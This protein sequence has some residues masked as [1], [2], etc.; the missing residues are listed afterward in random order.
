MT[1]AE[2]FDGP[3]FIADRDARGGVHGL[4]WNG[5][6]PEWFWDLRALWAEIDPQID[7]L[8]THEA[9]ARE[10]PGITLAGFRAHVFRRFDEAEHDHADAKK[11]LAWIG[12]RAIYSQA[13]LNKVARRLNER[14]RKTLGFTTPADTLSAGAT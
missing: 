8:S 12:A 11:A 10:G 9:G 4:E 3:G 14:P 13:E 2:A 1:P 6:A 7:A 5:N